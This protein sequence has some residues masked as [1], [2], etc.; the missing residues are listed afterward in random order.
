VSDDDSILAGMTLHLALL[1]MMAVGGGVIMLAPDIER[2]VAE[3]HHWIT[4]EQFTAAYAIAQASPGPNLL[5]VTLVGW[6]SA[7]WAGAVL[8]TLAIIVPPATLTLILLRVSR[9]AGVGRLGRAVQTGLAPVSVGLLLAGGL[10]LLRSVDSDWRQVGL[11]LVSVLVL[12]KTRLN[13]VW[14]ILAGGVCGLLGFV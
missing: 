1:S 9:S 13:P 5:Y 4:P 11:S 8:A 6:W 12:V 3:S 2:Y 10:V 7:G 14:L